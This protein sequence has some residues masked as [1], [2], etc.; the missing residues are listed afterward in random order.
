MSQAI[1]AGTGS[2]LVQLAAD[3]AHGELLPG[4]YANVSF[5]MPATSGHLN[6]PP[7]ALIFTKTGVQVATVNEESKVVLKPVVI[8]RDHGTRLELMSGLQ[9]SDKVIENPPDGV[10]QGDLVRVAVSE[11]KK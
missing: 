4:G 11:V 8:A 2:M 3:N 10:I 7:S 9:S 5:E 6:I 1:N